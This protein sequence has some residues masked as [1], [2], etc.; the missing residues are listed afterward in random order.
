MIMKRIIFWVITQ[1]SPLKVNRRFRGTYRQL[2]GRISWVLATYVLAGIFL[3]LFDPEDRGDMFLWNVGWL[4]TDYTALYTTTAVRT[5]NH[6][7][8]TIFVFT[9]ATTPKSDLYDHLRPAREINSAVL[10]KYK[11]ALSKY[12]INNM[13]AELRSMNV[14]HTPSLSS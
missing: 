8:I 10:S 6:T 2:Q 1:F 3:R 11:S 4:S 9:I 5:S 13:R 14:I 12:G 7:I